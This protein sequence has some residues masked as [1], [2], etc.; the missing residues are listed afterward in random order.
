MSF[1]VL[2]GAT[3]GHLSLLLEIREMT[4]LGRWKWA[5]KFLENTGF[6][7]TARRPPVVQVELIL[8]IWTA[9]WSLEFPLDLTVTKMWQMQDL[10][11]MSSGFQTPCCFL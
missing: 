10:K 7:L 8:D 9:L 4:S 11:S 6:Y 2:I 3:V 1:D 5:D